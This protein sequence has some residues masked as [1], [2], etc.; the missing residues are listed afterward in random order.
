MDIA[1]KIN[2]CVDIAKIIYKITCFYWRI[3][4]NCLE[5]WPEKKVN[6]VV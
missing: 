2:L 3:D 4:W 1:L 6:G 5:K